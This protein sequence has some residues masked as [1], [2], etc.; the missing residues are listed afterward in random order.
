MTQLD[1]AF[2]YG[3]EPGE[4]QMLAISRVREVY[5]VRKVTFEPAER[6]VRVEYDATRL[7]DPIIESLL[8]RAGLDIKERVALV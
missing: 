2:R 7:S 6:I 1:V 5:G 8:R 4:Q 3:L